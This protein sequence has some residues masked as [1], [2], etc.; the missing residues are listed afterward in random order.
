VAVGDQQLA[1]CELGGERLMDGRV[2]DPPD[3]VGRAVVV[4]DLSPRVA[5]EGG[6]EVPPGIA[7]MESEDG[8]EVVTGGAGEAQAVSLGPGWV[9]SCGRMPSP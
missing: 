1:G 8:G 2:A 9:R 7:G 3:P 6:L 4:G 5:G